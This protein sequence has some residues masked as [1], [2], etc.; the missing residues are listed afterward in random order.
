MRDKKIKN[1]T[2]LERIQEILRAQGLDGLLV[3]AMKN[4]R[5]LTGFTGS[6]GFA[7]ITPEKTFFYTDFRYKEQAEEEVKGWE[8]GMGR[9]RR[10]DTLERLTKKLGVKSLGFETSLSYGFFELLQGMGLLLAPQRD[11][12]ERLRTIK[13]AEEMASIR[14]AVERAETAFLKLLPKIREGITEKAI[15]LRLEDGLLKAGCRSLPFD[16]IVASGRHSSM[17]HAKPTDKKLEKGD[18]VIIDWGG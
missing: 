4:I 18:F 17:P 11:L 3:T 15:A 13:D 1:H 14:R 12:I 8:I 10:I 5:Y 9:L 7:L 2:R 6:S 16:I